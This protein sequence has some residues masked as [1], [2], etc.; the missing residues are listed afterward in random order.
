MPIPEDTTIIDPQVGFESALKNF[1][2]HVQ[3]QAPWLLQAPSPAPSSSGT[4]ATV[5]APAQR[6]RQTTVQVS[7]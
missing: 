7:P 4:P 5:P 3:A 2:R 1:N 6:G